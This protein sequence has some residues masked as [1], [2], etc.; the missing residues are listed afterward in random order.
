MDSPT[1]AKY[2]CETREESIELYAIWLKERL[3]AGD[4]AVRAAMNNI[5][6]MAKK[7]DINLVCYCVPLKCHCEVIKEIIEKK[8][9]ERSSGV[10]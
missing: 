3:E 5:Y 7:G 1:K 9:T 8:L 2:K 4:V 10:I 6:V